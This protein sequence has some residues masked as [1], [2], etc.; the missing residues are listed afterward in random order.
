MCWRIG[1]LDGVF[2]G[3]GSVLDTLAFVGEKVDFEKHF[4][5]SLSLFGV[6]HLSLEF[7]DDEEV[8]VISLLR[9]LL[10]VFVSF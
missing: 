5:R 10:R 8:Y 6:L 4:L 1:A 3:S 2:L 9:R 7:L